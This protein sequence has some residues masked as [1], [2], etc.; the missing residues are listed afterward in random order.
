LLVSIFIIAVSLTLFLYWFRYTCLLILSAKTSR[1]YT[2][3]IAT[4]NHLT[5]LETYDSLMDDT[6]VASFEKLHRSLDRDY[7]LLTY[8][9]RHGSSDTLPGRSLEN[10]I[11][12]IDFRLLSIWFVLTRRIS[13]ERARNA[14]LEMSSIVGH[15]ANTMGERISVGAAS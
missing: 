9:L 8:L 5:F 10:R 15:L 12:M 7:R 11:L 1:D 14:L 6:R 3:Q 4:A 13:S 2:A